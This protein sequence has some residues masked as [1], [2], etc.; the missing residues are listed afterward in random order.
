MWYQEVQIPAPLLFFEH[1]IPGALGHN[2]QAGPGSLH[3]GKGPFA[4]FNNHSNPVGK[5]WDLATNIPAL[6]LNPPFLAHRL[7]PN[8]ISP[9]T[10]LEH[11]IR[12]T[13][14]VRGLYPEK[15]RDLYPTNT[16]P[17]SST[18]TSV[19]IFV[20]SIFKAITPHYPSIVLDK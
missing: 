10:A 2:S 14:M 15:R 20:S 7:T 5:V 16:P 18:I 11:D 12:V 4:V 17:K 6:I 1:P 8:P 19:H 13:C 9:S 3:S